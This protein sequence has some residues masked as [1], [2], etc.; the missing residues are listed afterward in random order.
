MI[1]RKR[2]ERE[3]LAIVREQREREALSAKASA[4]L[5]M[6]TVL[7][8]GGEP[9]KVER[10]WLR[11]VQVK[12]LPQSR[13][14]QTLETHAAQWAASWPWLRQRLRERG[15]RADLPTLQDYPETVA[16]YLAK[17]M[18]NSKGVSATHK[19]AAAINFVMGLRDL[20][21]VANKTLPKAVK[22]S[23]NLQ[24]KRPRKK[25]GV[26]SRHEVEQVLDEWGS[27]ANAGDREW[28]RWVALLVGLSVCTL[29]RWAD[30]QFPLAGLYLPEG[31]AAQVCFPKRKNRQTGDVFW[32]SVPSSKT[33]SLLRELLALRGHSVSD[34]GEVQ[35]PRGA[36]LFPAL[37]H[38]AGSGRRA[39]AVWEV[40]EHFGRLGKSQ[41]KVYLKLFRRALQGCCGFTK[42]QSLLFSLHT[43]RRTGNTWLARGKPGVAPVSQDMRMAAGCWSARSSEVLYNELSDADRAALFGV[44]AV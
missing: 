7:E 30:A 35:A 12:H 19:A 4:I 15:V 17:V 6:S 40:K 33:L 27:D 8:D 32:A 29:A 36:F 31:Q 14:V 26:L 13:A 18:A 5:G 41:Y 11:Q 25:A 16:A 3:A 24:R 42:P 34:A 43:A 23:A 44:A 20:E 22:R 9:G 28:R 2:M 10:Y 37:V 39:D 21:P 1:A 38:R